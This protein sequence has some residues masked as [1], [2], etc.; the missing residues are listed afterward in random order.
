[1]NIFATSDC[2]TVSAQNLDD[3]RVNKMI[4]ESC[5]MLG[6]ALRV[7]GT[8]E[9]EL[10]TTKAGKPYGKTHQNH[11]CTLWAG[12]TQ[13]NYMWLLE[14]MEAL[15]N[16]FHERMHHTHACEANLGILRKGV[17][18]IPQGTRQ[19][20]QNSSQFK[21][22][23]DVCEAYRMTMR[24]KWDHLDKTPPKWSGMATRPHWAIPTG[25]KNNP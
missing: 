19:E 12:A 2:P 18:Y 4:L 17:Q 11:P 16:E 21:E 13:G 14:H 10:P 3:K 1:M 20:F 15:C 25:G 8:P 5:Q 24:F 6:T 7:H 9:A 22:I 23:R